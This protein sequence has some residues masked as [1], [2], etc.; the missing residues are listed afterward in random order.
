MSEN[1]TKTRPILSAPIP[2]ISSFKTIEKI[3]NTVHEMF[4]DR[5]YTILS[6]PQWHKKIQ[7]IEDLKCIAQKID[8]KVFVFF[9]SDPK[10]PVKKMRE[11]I[12][13]MDENKIAHAV[14][15]FAHQI[16][17]SAKSEIDPNRHDIEMFQAKEL[18]ENRTKHYLVPK[19]EKLESE[20]EIQ[21]ILHKYH[22]T[23]KNQLPR[24]DPDEVIVRYYH[25]PVGSVVKIYRKLGNQK[26]PEI[27][28]RHV[29][30]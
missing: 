25:W 24:Y 4:T 7:Q 29:R 20:E 30:L 26:E 6:K 18:F 12:Q 3:L 10:V 5:G 11:Y 2:K 19:H 8:D 1:E 15:V 17:P 13:I 14:I 16:T 9:A 22:L 21:Q 28:L 27:F 23:S